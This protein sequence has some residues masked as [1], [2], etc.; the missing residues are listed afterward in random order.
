M[1]LK[2]FQMSK[3]ISIHEYILKPGVSERQFESAILGA[4]KRGL[5]N[6]TGLVD[7]YLVKGIRGSRNGLYAAVWIYESKEAWE[8][9]W[10]PIDEPISKADYPE[11]WKSW[12]NEV[13]LPFLDQD[14]DNI[15]FTSYRE[16]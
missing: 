15:N 2:V 1:K 6:L 11:N 4:K 13:L 7:H 10:G 14:P 3:V 12:E 8:N 5:L 9:L 16:L